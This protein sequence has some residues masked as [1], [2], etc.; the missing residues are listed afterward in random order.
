[1]QLAALERAGLPTEHAF[2]SLKRSADV[3]VRRDA[4]IKHLRR[5][6]PIAKAG[7]LSG[8]FT[9]LESTLVAAACASGSPA[10]T[11]QRIGEQAAL[12]ARLNQQVRAQL[13]KPALLLIL[14][15]LISPL[16]SLVAGQL[17][18]GAYLLSA[19]WPLLWIGALLR[20]GLWIWQGIAQNP[21]H[22]LTSLVLYLPG[23]GK[24]YLRSQQRHFLASLAMLL[25]AGVSVFDAI[26]SALATVHCA[27]LRKTRILRH[28]E[29]GQTLSQSISHYAWLNDP[30]IIALIHTGEAS[31]RLP[32]MLARIADE[33]TT[34]LTHA[35]TQLAAWLPR[36]IY[37]AVA[38][39]IAWQL[40]ASPAF[41]PQL[42]EALK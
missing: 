16:P 7:L 11:Y 15:L 3:A 34:E 21:E 33:L 27:R 13:I 10:N 37:L 9:P 32:E 18:L 8:L 14:S 29:Q 31:G 17:R 12:H 19:I 25:E 42:P 28:L 36:M 23:L 6:K 38:L 41:S 2:A 4:M 39:W 26:E 24:W 30:S 40:L 20:I 35:A 22:P 1:M 5:G